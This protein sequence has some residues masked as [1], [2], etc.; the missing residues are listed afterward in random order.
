MNTTNQNTDELAQAVVV[1]G[2]VIGHE[3][4]P[5]AAKAIA[6]ALRDYAPDQVE[7][8]LR[9]CQRELTGRLTLAAILDRMENGH[10]GADEA[11]ALC[12]RSEAETVVWTEEIAEAFESARSLLERDP[13]AARMAFRDAYGRA[14]SAARSERRTANWLVSLGHDR[15]G[16]IAPLR[17][18]VALGRLAA[19]DALRQ[20]SPELPGYQA[21]AALAADNARGQLGDGSRK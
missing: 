11:W 15:G 5:A 12:P 17:R 9:K 21:L 1:T 3:V 8:A 19:E 18:A 16:R 20:V 6:L 2:E 4:T 7:A 13:V 14:V 10:V